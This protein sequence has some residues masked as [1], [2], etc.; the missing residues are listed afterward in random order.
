MHRLTA[1]L[2]LILVLVGTFVPMALAI[3]APPQHAC[4]MRKPMHMHGAKSAEW[5][6]VDCGR[7]S[8]CGSPTVPH[9]AQPSPPLGAHATH[10][11]A[12][13]LADA[14]IVPRA[15]QFNAVLSV[16]GPPLV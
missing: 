6:A 11:P 10:L 8:C 3:T 5:H 15:R 14:H 9:W 16:R 1:R 2:L 12:A 7:H 13:L 4:C